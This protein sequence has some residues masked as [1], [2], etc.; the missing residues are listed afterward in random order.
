MIKL[1]LA[2]R[3]MVAFLNIDIS[4]QALSI[5]SRVLA[6]E[7][8]EISP[9]MKRSECKAWDSLRHMELIVTVEDRFGLQLTYEEINKMNSLD[10]IIQIVTGRIQ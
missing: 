2:Q 8:S 1:I 4:S 6:I 7:P 3:G 10:E 9:L 5:L